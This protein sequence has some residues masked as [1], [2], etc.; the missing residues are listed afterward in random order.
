[1]TYSELFALAKNK[2]SDDFFSAQG[3]CSVLILSA[4]LAVKAVTRQ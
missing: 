4:F 1:M 3:Y 2:K